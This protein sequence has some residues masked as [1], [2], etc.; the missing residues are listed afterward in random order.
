MLPDQQ[1]LQFTACEAFQDQQVV[2]CPKK[3]HPDAFLKHCK[4]EACVLVHGF[5]STCMYVCS[6]AADDGDD[7]FDD[8]N[9]MQKVPDRFEGDL[10]RNL[11][12]RPLGSACDGSVLVLI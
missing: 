3:F 1:M 5:L 2:D 12:A 6:S 8:G 4:K 9:A 10:S 11:A 7:D